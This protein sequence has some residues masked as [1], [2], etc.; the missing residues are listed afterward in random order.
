[1]LLAPDAPAHLLRL[2]SFMLIKNSANS[3]YDFLFI[4]QS[5]H[6]LSDSIVTIGAG[7][8]GFAITFFG[9]GAFVKEQVYVSPIRDRD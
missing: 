3:A 5:P 9:I 2:I 4:K 7:E 1:M 8:Y 6:G